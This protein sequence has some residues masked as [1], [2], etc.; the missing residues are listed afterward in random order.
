[1]DRKR[2]EVL[3]NGWVRHTAHQDSN[4]KVS[5]V[6]ETP[7]AHTGDWWETDAVAYEGYA[8]FDEAVEDAAN[9]FPK[10]GKK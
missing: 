7:S 9:L 1:M 2:T 4:G 6:V 8:T 3:N 5:V 10:G